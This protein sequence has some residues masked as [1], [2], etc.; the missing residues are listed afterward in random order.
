MEPWSTSTSG[1]FRWNV[2]SEEHPKVADH[3]SR[4]GDGAGPQD[5]CNLEGGLVIPW[6]YSAKN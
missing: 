6:N 4:H 2:E 1:P 3:V 5:S